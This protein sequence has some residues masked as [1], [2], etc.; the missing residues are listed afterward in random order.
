MEESHKAIYSSSGKSVD[1][2]HEVVFGEK[3]TI[4]TIRITDEEKSTSVSNESTIAKQEDVALNPDENMN[5]SSEMPSS[6]LNQNFDASRN[7]TKSKRV[8]FQCLSDERTIQVT[9]IHQ[10]KD[11]IMC[12]D[13]DELSAGME[14][15]PVIDPNNDDDY[16]LLSRQV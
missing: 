7:F 1:S 8:S 14:N 5:I 13:D 4:Q 9:T 15:F 11:D 10:T 2:V 12:V 3:N 6:I 16:L